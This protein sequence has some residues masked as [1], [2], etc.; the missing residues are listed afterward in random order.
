M[1]GEFMSLTRRIFS[2]EEG[3]ITVCVITAGQKLKG[4]PH[5]RRVFFYAMVH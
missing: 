3:F 2:G 5:A 4:E 1:V